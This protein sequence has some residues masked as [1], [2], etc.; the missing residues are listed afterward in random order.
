MPFKYILKYVSLELQIYKIT[1]K[2]F[3]NIK[4]FAENEKEMECL[5]Q[6]IE[7]YS[8][9]VGME[10]DIDACTMFI[11]KREKRKIME[12]IKLPNQERIRTLEEKENYKYL[13]ILEVDTIK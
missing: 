10:F 13:R 1:K 4:L 2:I 6:T 12:G 9:D 3:D 5:I 7:I 8:Q 11:V